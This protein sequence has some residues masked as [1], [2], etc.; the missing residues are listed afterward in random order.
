MADNT[1][2]TLPA[3]SDADLTRALSPVL[4]RAQ[5]KTQQLAVEAY[6]AGNLNDAA[7]SSNRQLAS[8]T[9]PLARAHA[10]A[11]AVEK[12]ARS[13]N[14]SH[15]AQLINN[16]TG[17]LKGDALYAAPKRVDVMAWPAAVG[18]WSRIG[19]DANGD[20]KPFRAA[21]LELWGHMLTTL[22][23]EAT[24]ERLAIHAALADA[25]L[26]APTDAPTEVPATEA[27]GE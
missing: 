22:D 15:P 26:A 8:V 23:R 7:M 25:R 5:K 13:G 4:S 16:E 27:T 24:R 19:A 20:I 21:K 1:T 3:L 10:F 2:N 14:W 6:R 12:A 11:K 9:A 17:S 18:V